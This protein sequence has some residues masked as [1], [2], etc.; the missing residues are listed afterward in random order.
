MGSFLR[1]I[2]YAIRMLLKQRSY[3]LVALA[4]LS[5]GI[6]VNICIFGALNSVFLRQLP[7]E[8][9]DQLIALGTLQKGHDTPSD[10][11]Y[12]DYKDVQQEVRGSNILSDVFGYVI[13]F[14]AF[15]ADQHSERVLVTYTT[16][17]YFTVLGLNPF[18]GRL[19][20]PS[21]G[22]KSG[23]DNFAVL[24]YVFWKHR[25]A[26][27]PGVLGKSVYVDNHLATIV[28]IAP[29][30]FRGV[31]SMAQTD[32]FLPLNSIPL[33]GC[34]CLDDRKD[35]SLRVLA[36][37]A[38]GA[39]LD[40]ARSSLDVIAHRLAQE[41]PLE[42]KGIS[43]V[44][45]PERIAR[46]QPSAA[47]FWL[48]AF[49]MS[50]SFPLIVLLVA[51]FNLT[52]LL[53]IQ[54]TVR[55]AELGIRA[56][57]G[58][59][60]RDLVLQSLTETTLLSLLGS[61]LGLGAGWIALKTMGG[62][63]VPPDLPMLRP[64]LAFDWHVLLYVLGLTVIT[65]VIGGTAPA[66]AVWRTN[67]LQALHDRT[68][69]TSSGRSGRKLQHGLVT[70]QVAGSMVLLI[71][72][73]LYS[74]S[75]RNAVRMDL[76]FEPANIVNLSLDTKYVDYTTQQEDVFYKQLLAKTIALPGV[77]SAA[78][79]YSV[80]FG[81]Y[82]S[83]TPV[84]LDS[85]TPNR[86]PKNIFYNKVSSD[87]FTTL[88]IPVLQG[89]QFNEQDTE[90]SPPVAIISE[91]MWKSLWHNQDPI[92]KRFRMDS[93]TSPWL[94]VIGM[95]RDTT[96][97]NPFQGKLA[98]FYVPLQQ[99]HSSMRVLQV[100]THPGMSVQSI[101]TS[102]KQEVE[103]LSPRLPVFD[104][105]T[106]QE[107]LD[108]ANGFFIFRI[109]AILAATLAILSLFLVGVG[110]YGIVSY[111]VQQRRREIAIRRTLGANNSQ[112]MR[113]ILR[114]SLWTIGIGLAIGLGLAYPVG[115]AMAVIL[116]HVSP[117]DSVAYGIATGLLAFLTLMASY[118]PAR[119]ALKTDPAAS[120]RTE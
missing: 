42:D 116:L 4:T 28:G 117:N 12:L 49:S 109:G 71:V 87:Y 100:R 82:Q 80:P 106:M 114:Q 39:N 11:S 47:R 14:S 84:Y 10:F 97:W 30:H 8:E 58:A 104:V 76:G 72:A 41:N 59:Q 5:V 23:A 61:V 54:G 18:M 56:A 9:P 44:A 21:E 34:K 15:S 118:I 31:F 119:A 26:G 64:N 77:K 70:V 98:N 75:L 110:V 105:R 69:W 33:H 79:S 95:A 89:R 19:L 48:M 37:L 16:G 90:N 101:T 99:N 3:T 92:G 46:P 115:H 13:D 103:N 81:S 2:R 65:M 66:I 17:N 45:Y 55:K 63:F 24:S 22:E 32:I 85:T 43:I 108:G 62:L 1:H 102:I 73:A 86:R 96:F 40:K 20:L 38:P 78:Y 67:L 68:Q 113:A 111:S 51:C 52:N 112:I 74:R 91:T 35:R 93:A 53:L 36:R 25:F 29:E 60:K 27:D 120:L 94:T 50:I 7:V 88:K 6:G 57:L 107:S 83:S